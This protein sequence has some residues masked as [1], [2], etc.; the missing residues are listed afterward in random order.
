MVY[1][2]FS[3]HYSNVLMVQQFQ[4]LRLHITLC[5]CL[6]FSF[7]PSWQ[8]FGQT[9]LSFLEKRFMIN[10]QESMWPRSDWFLG[11]TK[12]SFHKR[13]S[14]SCHLRCVWHMTWLIQCNQ[15]SQ[16]PK[17]T[18]NSQKL[19]NKLAIGWQKIQG[20]K[21]RE[22]ELISKNVWGKRKEKMFRLRI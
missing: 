6:S 19:R 12:K 22:I 8:D 2:L 13:C 1:L 17:N 21:Q 14:W 16:H 4:L 5:N 3:K 18:R 20:S 7:S 11:H 15:H 9:A 10:Y